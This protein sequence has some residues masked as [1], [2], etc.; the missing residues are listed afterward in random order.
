MSDP[1]ADIFGRPVDDAD[2]ARESFLAGGSGTFSG[3][4]LGGAGFYFLGPDPPIHSQHDC[5]FDHGYCQLSHGHE[6]PHCVPDPDGSGSY[7]MVDDKG[8]I[9]REL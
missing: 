5:A 2:K 6:L 9:L 3:G 4:D 7:L 1:A 8:R